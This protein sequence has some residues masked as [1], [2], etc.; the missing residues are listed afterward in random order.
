MSNTT[1]LSTGLATTGF[2]SNPVKT[3]SAILDYI[4]ND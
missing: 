4:V 3:V 1:L 2:G